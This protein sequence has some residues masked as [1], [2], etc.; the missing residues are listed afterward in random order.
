M[1]QHMLKLIL[2][3]NILG[4]PWWLSGNAGMRLQSPGSGR[5]GEGNGNPLQHSCL[6][7]P[8]DKGAWWI[9]VQA[10]CRVGH[11][12]YIRINILL[13]FITYY[14]RQV[15]MTQAVDCILKSI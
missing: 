14:S 6:G 12:D 7:N 10:V 5:S 4:F 8:M 15:E 11:N 9:I 13:Q 3:I 2:S 1:C